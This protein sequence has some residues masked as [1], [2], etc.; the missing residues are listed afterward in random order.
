[1]FNTFF[2]G[3]SIRKHREEIRKMKKIKKGY[4]IWLLFVF[5][6][7]MGWGALYAETSKAIYPVTI[8]KVVTSEWGKTSAVTQFLNK[9]H[10]SEN[11]KKISRIDFIV[12]IAHGLT[13][14]ALSE[15]S[16]NDVVHKYVDTTQL[17]EM[18]QQALGRVIAALNIYPK[19]EGAFFNP[20]R[21]ITRAEAGAF[22]IRF[23]KWQQHL[24]EMPKKTA[25]DIQKHWGRSYID[26]LL[27][28]GIM[29]TY[30][31]GGEDRFNPKAF[32]TIDEAK[33]M[34]LK[35]TY[36][37]V[38]YKTEDKAQAKSKKENQKTKKVISLSDKES[39]KDKKKQSEEN[40][41]SKPET[42]KRWGK[43]PFKKSHYFDVRS[44]DETRISK[45][46]RI[47]KSQRKPIVQKKVSVQKKVATSKKSVP[48]TKKVSVAKSKK[49]PI[50][51]KKPV[52][53]GLK[54]SKIWKHEGE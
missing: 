2:F 46:K 31:V 15:P 44:V 47:R 51:I 53:K 17:S 25:A 14:T 19:K 30:A 37:K 22:L 42:P 39:I 32:M 1:M 4:Q 38:A 26:M 29:K 50:R 48:Q 27:G 16:R 7:N 11:R 40:L 3:V 10:V 12:L 20:N 36:I 35:A 45:K 54:L 18:Q 8:N 5:A 23:L 24:G 21:A 52:S 34:V 28:V 6:I 33:S 13:M 41:D 9:A 49:Q 43:S